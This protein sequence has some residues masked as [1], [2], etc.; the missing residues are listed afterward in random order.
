[1]ARPACLER[2]G[3]T[4]YWLGDRAYDAD[5][6]RKRFATK[7][8]FPSSTADELRLAIY[9]IAPPASWSTLSTNGYRC[10]PD[11]GSFYHFRDGECESILCVDIRFDGS[12][13]RE[14]V[15]SA[16]KKVH[17][18]NEELPEGFRVFG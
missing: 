15:C 8:L 16:L 9:V 14:L 3:R 12:N 4:A 1:M 2:A 13:Q 7:E 6:L 11:R 5:H 18:P 10:L 17:V